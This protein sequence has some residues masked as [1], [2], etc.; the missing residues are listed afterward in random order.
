VLTVSGLT[1]ISTYAIDR[2]IGKAWS[3][4]YGV[5]F[6]SYLA[7]KLSGTNKFGDKYWAWDN[8]IPGGVE[9]WEWAGGFALTLYLM[10]ETGF[11]KQLNFKF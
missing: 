10:S 3:H 2:I 8:F 7:D 1:G 6:L 11:L 5:S 4:P 9:S